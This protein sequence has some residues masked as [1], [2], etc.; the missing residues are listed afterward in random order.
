MGLERKH[1]YRFTYLKSEHWQ[2]LRI[3]RIAKAKGKCEFCQVE[4]GLSLDVHHVTYR[5]LYDVKRKDLR[6]LCRTCH[7]AVH[8]V[9]EAYPSLYEVKNPHI[10]WLR[11]G[12][13]TKKWKLYCKRY[14]ED[15]AKA[16]MII[17]EPYLKWRRKMDKRRAKQRLARKEIKRIKHLIG[18]YGGWRLGRHAN[19]VISKIEHD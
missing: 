1:F 2:N 9:L 12:K 14:G 18:W 19:R 17:R 7:S 3:A 11:V 6:A 13:M 16:A 5:N 10:R 15:C 4:D 8:K